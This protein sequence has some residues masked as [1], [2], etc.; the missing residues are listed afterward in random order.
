MLYFSPCASRKHVLGNFAIKEI[1]AAYKNIKVPMVGFYAYGEIGS[2]PGGDAFHNE[3]V[4]AM[5]LSRKDK[6]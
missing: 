1:E 3:T 5:L 2:F 6:R 4:V